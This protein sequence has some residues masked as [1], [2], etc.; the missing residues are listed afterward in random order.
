MV[1]LIASISACVASDPTQ[2]RQIV[3]ADDLA[4]GRHVAQTHCAICHAMDQQH[5]S[6]RPGAPPLSTVLQGYDP[7]LLA[8]DFI[9]GVRVGHDGM[10]VFDLTVIDADALV[11]YLRSINGKASP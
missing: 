6:P 4:A 5:E 8:S 11:A 1:T 9:E 3:E 7:D 2:D 10:P